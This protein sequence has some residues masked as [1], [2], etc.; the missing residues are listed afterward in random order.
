MKKISLDQA[1]E[2]AEKAIERGDE[3]CFDLAVEYGQIFD[4]IKHMRWFIQIVAET[5]YCV[6]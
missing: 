2:K 4:N 1:L 3:R 6:A 5:L